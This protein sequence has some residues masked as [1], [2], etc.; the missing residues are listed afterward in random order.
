MTLF[1]AGRRNIAACRQQRYVP[2]SLL[3]QL[4]VT[5][6]CNLRCAHCYQETYQGEELGFRDLIRILDQFKDL[7]EIWQR[8]T[9]R[10]VRGHV[11][12]TGG[13]P[14]VRPDFM[15]LLDVIAGRV[16]RFAF[17]ILTNGSLIDA[18]VARHMKRLGPAFV[19]VSIEGLRQSHDRIRGEGQFDRAVMGIEALVQERIRTLISFT[20]RRD[21]FREFLDVAR[22]GRQ[23][24]VARI[25]ADRMIPW[26]SGASLSDQIL[27]PEE[28]REFFETMHRAREECV[29]RWFGRTEI[30]MHRALEFL[31]SGDTPYRCA[32]GDTLITVMPNGDVFPC[33]RMPVR[34]GNLL[35]EPL[36]G[37]YYQS[38][39]LRALR[40]RR[41][42]SEGCEDCCYSA[43]C[44]GGLK[45]LSYAVTDDPFKADPGC[46]LAK[47]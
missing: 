15:D 6:R 38:D 40:D 36:E 28:T 7:L 1:T 5:D 16:D 10:S 9:G 21:N 27:S 8:E 13:E 25:W 35:E 45:C 31:V 39:F 47:R 14:F 34:V 41:R 42:C 33:R 24:K 32:A 29:H 17:A 22:L 23:L 3:L 18:T 4:H 20:A 26:G 11:T 12:V 43:L 37:L 19:Q 46:W 44:R 2:P 30:A